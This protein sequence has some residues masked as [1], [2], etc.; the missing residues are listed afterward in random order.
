M[1]ELSDN[2]LCAQELT[3]FGTGLVHG[4]VQR[5][6]YT[7]APSFCQYQR[8]SK[9]SI[10]FAFPTIVVIVNGGRM[11]NIISEVLEICSADV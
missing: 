8:C 7:E 5:C 10:F 3:L 11:C 2:F 6:I 9:L 1:M 4:L